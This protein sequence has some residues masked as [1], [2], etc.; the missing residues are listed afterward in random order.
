MRRGEFRVQVTC[1]APGG[2]VITSNEIQVKA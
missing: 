2:G 1:E